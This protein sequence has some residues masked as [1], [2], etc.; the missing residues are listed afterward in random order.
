MVL[1]LAPEPPVPAALDAALLHQLVKTAFGHRRKTLNNTL[2]ARGRR[3][4][5][6]PRGDAGPVGAVGHRPHT[7]GRN[8]ERGGICGD[9]QPGGGLRGE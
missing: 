3:L 7:P 5:V 1:R 2:V 6:N 4:R 8:P 9:E